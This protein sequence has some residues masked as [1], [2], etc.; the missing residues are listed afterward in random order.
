M[1][2]L[3]GAVNQ[4]RTKGV[5]TDRPVLNEPQW[6][7]LTSQLDRA[8]RYAA[9]RGLQLSY[10]PHVG[11]GVMTLEETERLLDS[12]SSDTVGL[13]L[14]TAHLCYGGCS[15]YQLEQLTKKYASADHARPFEECPPKRAERRQ[16]RAL[17]LL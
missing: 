3:A 6:R 16:E 15:Q 5:L 10:H 2:E 11:T 4:I 9:E 13:C 1:A 7:L 17:Q 8:G 12:T 14:D